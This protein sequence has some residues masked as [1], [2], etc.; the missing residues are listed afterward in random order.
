MLLWLKHYQ[1]AWLAGDIGAGVVVALMLIPQGMA[2][3]LL[4]GLPPVAG[5]YA[6]ILPAFAYALFGSSMV[7][8]VG[9]MAITSL[10]TGTALASMAVAGSSN[11]LL[12]AAELAFLAGLML[13]MCGIG[14]LGF[15]ANFLSRPVMSGFTSGVALLIIGSQCAVLAGLPSKLALWEIM[16]QAHG[17]SA[18][19]GILSLLVLWMSQRWSA[20]LLRKLGLS[21]A[22]ATILS[23]LVPVFVLLLNTLI[24][25][26]GAAWTVGIPVIGHVPSGLPDLDA[27]ALLALKA[28]F[29]SLLMPAALIAFIIFMSS[30]S[31]ALTLAQKRKEHIDANRE[32]LGLGAANVAAALS[33]GFPVTGSI[34]RSAVNHVAGANSP[35]ATLISASLLATLLLLPGTWLAPLASIPLPVMAAMIITAV[36][37]MIDLELIRVAW[38]YDRADAFALFATAAGVLFLGI[39][40]GVVIG[41]VLSLSI[42]I[43]RTSRPHMAVIGRLPGTEHFRNVDR[44]AVETLADTLMLRVDAGIF[45]GNTAALISHIDQQLQKRPEIRHLVLVMSAVNFIDTSGLYALTEL[46]ANLGERGMQLHLCEVKGPVMDRLQGSPLIKQALTGKIF[47]SAG[48]AYSYLSTPS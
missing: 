37:G 18:L 46:N 1:R 40:R 28:N 30:Q 4:A 2:Y 9:P 34:S 26:S 38:R 15:L 12:L 41:V 10:M 22:G 24:I 3:A 33:G 32:L 17:P 20:G 31:A 5:L 16:P 19:M 11:Y 23:R 39:E 7:Q 25:L 43:G 44:H 13:I 27:G 42:L 35:L 48:Q 14:R 29:S 45:F 47:L 21:S 8:S 36:I 6:S